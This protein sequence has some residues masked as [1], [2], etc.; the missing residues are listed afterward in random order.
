MIYPFVVEGADKAPRIAEWIDLSFSAKDI[1]FIQYREEIRRTV[2]ALFGVMPVFQGDTGAGVGLANEGLQ[3]VVTNRA[4]EREQTLF[5]EKVLPWLIRQMGVSDWE[6]QLIPNE[7]RD[8]VARIQ[9]E[10]MRIGN[11]ER[12]AA[13]GYKPVAVKTDDGIDFYYEVGGKEIQE[14]ERSGYIASKVYQE[15][16]EREIPRYEGEPEHGRPRTD[17]QRFEG[18]ELGRRP[19]EVDTFVVGE[20]GKLIPE[21]EVGKGFFLEKQ[22][23][24]PEEYRRY[25]SR[26]QLSKLPVGTRVH[27][28]PRGGM[29]IDVREIPES[30]RERLDIEP[31][32]SEVASRREVKPNKYSGSAGD[33]KYEAVLDEASGRSRVSLVRGDY[34]IEFDV[35]INS[36]EIDVVSAKIPAVDMDSV[37]EEFDKL[38]SGAVYESED[39]L[40]RLRTVFELGAAEHMKNILKNGETESIASDR[41]KT[42]VKGKDLYVG[43]LG[44]YPRISELT[45]RNFYRL[46]GSK[47]FTQEGVLP[48]KVEEKLSKF[49]EFIN[50][51]NIGA[52][53][54]IQSSRMVKRIRGKEYSVGG[55]YHPHKDVIYV[56]AYEIERALLHEYFHQVYS[57][58]SRLREINVL[59]HRLKSLYYHN[60]LDKFEKDEN[61]YKLPYDNEK[62]KEVL[63]MISGRFAHSLAIKARERYINTVKGDKVAEMVRELQKIIDSYGGEEAVEAFLEMVREFNDDDGLTKYSRSYFE[64]RSYFTGEEEEYKHDVGTE[65]F[66]SI[67]DFIRVVMRLADEDEKVRDFVEKHKNKPYKLLN[68][69]LYQRVLAS[70]YAGTLGGFR[71]WGKDVERKLK[72]ASKSLS[73]AKKVF[74]E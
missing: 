63:D 5:N 69:E 18:E 68:K 19:K 43:E 17:E 52:I 50:E 24:V 61:I 35:D 9:R 41:S 12:M 46:G 64:G 54:V 31:E 45:Q 3:I 32:G 25:I 42:V 33:L 15:I 49:K 56:G 11:A 36:G 4:V 16:P 65:A 29:F 2:G 48:T 10:T 40:E 21:G 22:T 1:E 39:M 74:R 62:V 67:A 14:S 26:D 51:D 47:V 66:A 60:I 59:V 73:V 57:I 72:V 37:M 23:A 55:F 71:G 6:Y 20:G 8:V 13:L 44:A 70:E 53:V 30:V 38:E 28:G 34:S 58:C 7:G 27:R